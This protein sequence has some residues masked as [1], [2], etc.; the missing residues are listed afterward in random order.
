MAANKRPQRAIDNLPE[1]KRKQALDA[2]L[3]GKS[4]RF[5]ASLVGVSHQAVHDYKRRVVMPAIETAQQVQAF[6]SFNCPDSVR[7]VQHTALTRDI[8]HSSPFRERL[9]HLWEKTQN[10]LERAETS[11]RVVQDEKTGKLVA[12]GPDVAAIAPILNQAHKNV[13]MLGVATGEIEQV[14]ANIAIQIV[15][16]QQPEAAPVASEPEPGETIDITPVKL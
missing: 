1:A 10:A 15:L 14:A 13:H 11:V 5:V 6:Q 8:V 9:E 4:L 16:P 7:A 3:A 2:L 12:V